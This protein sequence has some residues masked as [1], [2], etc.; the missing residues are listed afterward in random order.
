A[1]A[2]STRKKRSLCAGCSGTTRQ[3]LRQSRSRRR[4]TKTATQARRVGCGVRARFTATQER[5]IGILHNELYVGRLVWNRQRFLKDPDTG[6]RVARTNP[7]SEWITK[8]VPELRI[9]DDEV[10]QAV[11]TRYASVQRKWKK[12]DEGRRFNQFRRPK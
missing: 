3:G 11:Q 8:D 12:A 1:N 5:G 7:R 2:R 10:W 9:V 4:S 6:K